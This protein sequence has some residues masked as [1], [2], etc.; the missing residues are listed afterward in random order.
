VIPAR[1]VEGGATDDV[2]LRSGAAR[3]TVRAMRRRL[4]L[5]IGLLAATLAT[6]ASLTLGCGPSG[7]GD[8]GDG[9]P[10]L[11]T[12]LGWQ[13]CLEP[14]VYADPVAC[15]ADQLCIPEVGCAVCNPGQEYCGADNEVWECNASGTAGTLVSACAAGEV[16]SNGDCKTPCE[17][18]LDEPSNVGCDFWATDLDN[19]AVANFI[20]NDAAA[21]QYSVVVANNNDYEVQ[22]QV[23]KNAARVGEP[24]REEVVLAVTV[25]PRTVR[26]LDLPQRE[27]DGTMG[28][29]GPYRRGTGAHTFVSPHAYHV[30]SSGPVVAY[31]FNP[32]VQQ[33][34]NDASILIP[35]QA[36]GRHHYVF[37]WPTANPCGPPMGEFGY[38]DSIPDRTS[39]TIVGVQDDTQVTVT[40]THPIVGSSGDSGFAIPPTPA[41]T[42]LTFTVNRYDVVNLE[43]D[44]P[45]VPLTQCFSM[46]DRDGDFTGS[47]V[48]STKSVAVFTAHERGI[49]LGGATPPEPP[50]WDGDGCCTDHLEEQLFPTTAWGREFAIARS[51]VRSTNPGYKEPDVYRVLASEDGTVVTTSLGGEQATFTLDAGQFKP[52]WSDRGFT[53]SST[54]PITVGQVLVSQ[55]RIPDGGTGDPSLLLV[56]AAEQFRKSYVFLVPSTFSK[57]YMVLAIPVGGSFTV[58][59][60]SL[61]EFADCVR[62]PIGVVAGTGYE[63]VTCLMSEGGH[64]VEGD[65]AFG[66]FV[67]G[68]YAVGSYSFAGGSDVR[69]INPID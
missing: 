14:G 16:C 59:G 17:R 42:P 37:G 1:C 35:I 29:N 55:N 47:L 18:A 32:I 64:T 30:I 51:P 22:V 58:D 39:I 57:N 12:A 69:I 11:C 38:M 15:E 8:D 52:L 60:R 25:A 45:V 20:S 49:G 28:Q 48:T 43:S 27:V 34:S 3:T 21:Q 26:Q 53:I 65:Q 2:R 9:C 41:G 24:V 62:A 5:A 10:D 23:L 66:L 46:L 4:P 13:K 36:L 6:L 40:P 7:A 63:Q 19:E 67:Y 61:G 56:P 68:Y 31:Q 50:G 33:F 54:L 44:Q